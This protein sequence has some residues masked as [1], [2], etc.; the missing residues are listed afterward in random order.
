MNIYFQKPKA[1]KARRFITSITGLAV[2]LVAEQFSINSQAESPGLLVLDKT[3]SHA[4]ESPNGEAPF[5][6][7]KSDY[8]GDLTKLPIGVFDSGIGGLTVLEAILSLD[9][10]NNDNL[11]PEADG[12][13]DFTNERFIYLGDQANMPYGN[14]AARGKEDYLRE[15]ILKDTIFLLGKRSFDTPMSPKPRFD[16]PPVKAIV[17]ACNTA[18]AYGLEDVR[19][20][21]QKWDIPVFVVGVVE[22]GAR[23]VNELISPTDAPATIAIMATVGTCAS[24]AYPKAIDRATGL[25]GKRIP[26]VIQQGSV[27]LAG[28][29][30]GD[31]AFI[32]NSQQSS[33][34]TIADYIQNDVTSLVENF[35]QSGSKEPIKMVVLGCTHFPLVE[36]EI[37]KAFERLRNMDSNNDGKPPYEQLIAEHLLVVDPAKLVAKELFRRLAGDRLRLTGTQTSILQEDSFY[38]SVPAPNVAASLKTA[39]GDLAVEYKYGRETEKLEL[40]DTRVV[41]MQVEMLPESSRTLIQSRLPQV[42]KR[43]GK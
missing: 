40:E 12:R 1:F 39:S 17:I 31:P 13:P 29:I 37:L 24:N 8:H 15:L 4:I 43:L 41:P 23:G 27:A 26:T 42:W 33:T 18:T 28:A 21:I 34:A 30:E 25:A 6:F 32:K 36:E 22:S 35:R 2:F 16:K 5:S 19:Q 11:R 10:F 38:M 3:V 9:A 14:Y 7:D 20:A